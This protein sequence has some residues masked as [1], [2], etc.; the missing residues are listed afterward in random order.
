MKYLAGF[1]LT[2]AVSAP[3]H[4]SCQNI[5]GTWKVAAGFRS[6][7]GTM[8][9]DVFQ[10][11]NFNYSKFTGAMVSPGENTRINGKCE[12]EGSSY[13]FSFNRQTGSGRQYWTGYQPVNGFRIDGSWEGAGGSGNWFAVR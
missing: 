5:G 4:A 11:G 6:G 7:T 2:L 13:K 10:G 3:A 12:V 8:T 9:L 1:L